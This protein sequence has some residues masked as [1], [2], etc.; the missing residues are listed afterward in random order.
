MDPLQRLATVCTNQGRT[1]LNFEMPEMHR[2]RPRAQT[3]PRL[4]KVG[5]ILILPNDD[6]SPVYG[7]NPFSIAA[8]TQISFSETCKGTS[9]GWP[10]KL[11][12]LSQTSRVSVAD[13][14]GKVPL[15][16]SGL[17]G[18]YGFTYGALIQ[19]ADNVALGVRL[20][21]VVSR[22]LESQVKNVKGVAPYVQTI[23]S[24]VPGIGPGISGAISAGLTLAQGRPIDEALVDAV[25]GAV[26][27]G[28]LAKSVAKAGFAVASG[29]PF[30]DIAISA[31]P[32]PPAAKDGLKAGSCC[33]GCGSRETRRQVIPGRSES[34]D[35]QASACISEGRS[36]RRRARSGEE[37][38]GHRQGAIA[39]LIAVGGPLAAIGQKI[40]S[41]SPIVRQA[42]GLVAKGQHGFD[43]AQGLLAH[44]AVPRHQLE[45][46]RSAF[47]GEALKGFDT[48]VALHM[49]RV[50]SP[51]RPIKKD[52]PAKV[53]RLLRHEGRSG[54]GSR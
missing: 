27:G 10:E 43:V 51:P 11:Y 6:T 1:V 49:G 40:A 46:A 44:S 54:R 17:K 53:R 7:K 52:P 5:Q 32:I 4:R 50:L 36:G 47:K 2:D 22:H 48:A 26:P 39:R 23:I 30:S 42:R 8:M 3:G 24:L 9:D 12:V 15:I 18:L 16:G 29:K 20:D 41:N 31:L 21:K 13:T 14:L 34:S 38:S 37:G 25:A 19:S 45:R 28:A 33:L 35:R